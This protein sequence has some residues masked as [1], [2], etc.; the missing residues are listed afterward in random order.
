VH[1]ETSFKVEHFVER[2]ILFIYTG[3]SVVVKVF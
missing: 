3:M 1:K 2:G